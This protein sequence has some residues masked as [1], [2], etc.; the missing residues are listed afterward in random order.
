M[1]DPGLP[2]AGRDAR[3]QPPGNAAADAAGIRAEADTFVL[4]RIIGNDLPPRHAKGQSLGNLRFLLERE[5]PLAGCEKRWVVNR[6]VDADEEAAILALL[7]AHGQ[8]FLHIPFV[9]DEY[10]EVGWDLGALQDGLV[11]SREF[12][13]IQEKHR[14]RAYI[15]LCRLKT[16]YITNN[17]G[18]RNAAL[19]DG[20]ARAKWVLPWD[21]NCLLTE[22]AWTEIAAAVAANPHAKYIAVPMQR[23][24]D[25]EAC[26]RDDF[27]ADPGDEPQ[28][29]FRRDAGEEFDPVHPWGRRPKVDLLWRLGVAGPWDEW[30]H[31][32]WDFPRPSLSREAGQFATAGWVARLFSGVPDLEEAG[33]VGVVRRGTARHEAIMSAIFGT[34]RRLGGPLGGLA[35]PCGLAFYSSAALDAARIGLRDGGGPLGAIAAEIVAE[36]E[37]TL[38]HGPWSVVQKETATPSGDLHDYYSPAPYFWP[39]PDRPDGL[40]YVHRDGQRM[41]DA[42]LFSPGGGRYDRTRLQMMFDGTTSL[43]LAW[44]LTGRTDFAAHGARFVRA[45]FVDPASRMNPHLDYAQVRLGHGS[46]RGSR[47]GVIEF[48]DIYYFLDAVR[49]LERAGALGEQDRATFRNWLADYRGWLQESEPGR[50]ERLAANNHGTYFDLQAAAIECYLG[51]SRGLGIS[52]LRAMSR[53]AQQFTPEGGQPEETR[54]PTSQ[55]YLYFNLQGWLHLLLLL[56]AGG[57]YD[58]DY[59]AEPYPR[60]AAAVAELRNLVGRDLPYRQIEPFDADRI[61]PLLAA[62]AKLGLDDRADGAGLPGAASAKPR[63]DPMA[64]V[65]PY[66][67]LAFR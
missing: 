23:L 45:W 65:A 8:A 44:Y 42:E 18:A 34:H 61:H 11:I 31:D 17:N 50:G 55:H 20:R 53:L 12:Q 63:F 15:A 60:L 64:G 25:N 37:R 62:A 33:Q 24:V 2:G 1:F 19:A 27:R 13:A 6:I 5:P 51:D 35:D 4:Y 22:A 38:G 14:E 57:C 54:R 41:P 16:I 58:V 10:R 49:L 39:D 56:R 47:Y 21:G 46:D 40:P 28:L 7:G 66:W 67:Q 3:S 26:F 36:A 48:K 32:P 30:L 52:Y 43:A 59:A 9:L 29:I